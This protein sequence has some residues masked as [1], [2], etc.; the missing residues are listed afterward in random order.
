VTEQLCR[1]LKPSSAALPGSTLHRIEPAEHYLSP[2]GQRLRGTA[3]RRTAAAHPDVAAVAVHVVPDEHGRARAQLRLWPHPGGE[4]T[5]TPA[6]VEAH[7][8]A[9]GTPIPAQHILIADP[10]TR[11]PQGGRQ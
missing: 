8:T 6:A 11:R 5:L 10:T 3:L 7:C 4:Q 1:S 9:Q 2:T